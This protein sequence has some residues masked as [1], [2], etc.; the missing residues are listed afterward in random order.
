MNAIAMYLRLSEEDIDKSDESNSVIGQRFIIENY[1]QKKK[2]YPSYEILEFVDDGYSG[3]NMNRPG[4]TALLEQVKLGKVKCIIVKDLSRFSR[5]Y[6][7]L[8]SYMEQIFPFMKVRFIAINDGYDSEKSNGGIGEID[9]QF[10]GLLY[11]FYSKDLS[12][13]VKS[14][15]KA[16]VKT[17][18]AITWA[19]PY[20]YI[21]NPEDSSRFIIDDVTAPIVKMIYNL[22]LEGLS[23]HKIAKILN[24]KKIPTP[25]MR[26]EELTNISYNLS[27]E[28]PK[29]WNLSTL[30]RITSNYMYTGALVSNTSEVK[31]VGSGRTLANSKENWIVV[32]DTHEPIISK[33]DFDK[34]QEIKKTRLGTYR[35]GTKTTSPLEDVMECGHCRR[36]MSYGSL[37]GIDRFFYCR[38]SIIA[39]L[40]CIKDKINAEK[41]E[42]IIFQAVNNQL[43]LYSNAKKVFNKLEDI[44]NE[45]M[46]EV[47]EE[48]RKTEADIEK[49]KIMIQADYE[50]FKLGE[51]TKDEFL[52]R[53]NLA[54]VEI[55]KLKKTVKGRIKDNDKKQSDM[56]NKIGFIKVLD[57]YLKATKLTKEMANSLIE[58][59]IFYEEGKM[60][61]VWK[62]EVELLN[63]MGQSKE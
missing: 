32:E 26:K 6:L 18:K 39:D 23:L 61:I 21:K 10:K 57:K 3:T 43:N 19:A 38:M 34:V 4:I 42:D 30:S 36:K 51:L 37:K 25:A 20:G 46:I 5:D 44:R 11:D 22:A 52:I 2:L 24:E 62:Y 58:K 59:I 49:T 7:E 14:N 55:E 12:K 28:K 15:R 41:L 40:G 35:K 1:I 45:K 9:V 29:L 27:E 53:K 60:E 50:K 33:E 8:G 48:N 13:K 16:K 31:E 47:R 56:E 63:K 54:N 17:G